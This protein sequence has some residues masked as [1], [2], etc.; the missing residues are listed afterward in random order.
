MLRCLAR[1]AGVDDRSEGAA[2]NPDL[3]AGVRPI[4]AG[5]G[6]SQALQARRSTV[7]HRMPRG[8]IQIMNRQWLSGRKW[9]CHFNWW[10]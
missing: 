3:A 8:S 7:R 5:A 4:G 2:D 1:H 10:W 9:P 6:S